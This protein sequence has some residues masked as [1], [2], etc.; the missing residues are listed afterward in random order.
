MNTKLLPIQT[1]EKPVLYLSPHDVYNIMQDD[2]NTK[3][4]IDLRSAKKFAGSKLRT[5]VNFHLEDIIAASYGKHSY[6]LEENFRLQLYTL[7]QATLPRIG[8][9]VDEPTENNQSEIE[10]AQNL[11]PKIDTLEG[12]PRMFSFHKKNAKY[13]IL[14]DGDILEKESGEFDLALRWEEWIKGEREEVP[15]L[16]RIYTKWLHWEG[17]MRDTC[18]CVVIK[19]GH[20]AFEEKYPFLCTTPRMPSVQGALASEIL[21]DFLF[22]GSRRNVED[23]RQLESLGITHIVNMAAEIDNRYPEHK[24]YLKAGIDDTINDSIMGVVA[25]CVQFIEKTRLADPKNRVLVHCAMGISRSSSIVIAY[26]MARNKWDFQIAYKFVR[27]R[28]SSINPNPGFRSQLIANEQ[29]IC[30]LL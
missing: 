25:D 5:A 16:A 28:R 10:L 4:I 12:A 18:H 6:T 17:K 2:A 19:G 22:L 14:Y 23:W 11:L 21:E 20:A 29:L 15:G 7:I 27:D 24:V 9:R 26:L 3:L 8:G 30:S 13:I 1:P